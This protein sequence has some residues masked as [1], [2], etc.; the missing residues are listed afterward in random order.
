MSTATA[1]RTVQRA[2]PRRR[3]LAGLLAVSLALNVFFIVGAVW[4]RFNGPPGAVDFDQR[5]RQMAVQLDLSP[6]QQIAFQ[7]YDAAMQTGREAMR[8]HIRPLMDAVRQEI[9][10]Q[11]PDAARIAQLLDRTTAEHHAFQQL[12]INNTLAFV[13]TLSP[14]QR[15]RFLAIERQHWQQPHR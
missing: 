12:A 4:T 8:R 1:G 13:A 7:R 9:A 6:R 5:L 2:W 3:L 15:S 10:K 11:Q 14:A